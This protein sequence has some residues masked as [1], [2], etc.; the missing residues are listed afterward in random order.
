MALFLTL[1]A[2]LTAL[3]AHGVFPRL[4]RPG[5]RV[6]LRLFLAGAFSI[7]AALALAGRGHLL[8]LRPLLLALAAVAGVAAWAGL[9]RLV[10]F[11]SRRG[12]TVWRT[13][14]LGFAVLVFLTSGS[15]MGT[16]FFLM[17]G[18]LMW[19]WQRELK[20]RSRFT[21]GMLALVI[22]IMLV[23]HTGRTWLPG[24]LPRAQETLEGFAR[25]MLIAASSYA[26]LGSFVLLRAWAQDPS[27]GIRRV[28]HRLTLSHILVGLI[29]VLLVGALW[30]AT[31]ILGV[32]NERA[33]VGARAIA[34]QGHW[35]QAQLAD[36]I[37]Q[38]AS[39]EHR[40]SAF[41]AS[42]DS[43]GETELWYGRAGRF[44]RIAG[45][46]P[47]SS[48]RLEA[49][50]A[51]LDSLPSSGVVKMVDS[52]YVGAAATAQ[53]GTAAVMLVPHARATAG[54]PSEVSRVELQLLGIG[55]TRRVGPTTFQSTDDDSSTGSGSAAEQDSLPAAHAVNAA[56]ELA[57]SAQAADSAQLARSR[58]IF[59][60][61][62]IPDR[63]I[64][65]D[66]R[67]DSKRGMRISVGRES[68]ALREE[69][70]SFLMQGHA[71]SAGI[72]WTAHGWSRAQFM[73]T[74]SESPLRVLLGLFHDIRTNPLGIIPVILVGIFVILA[75]LVLAWNLMMVNGMG[76]SIT[77]AVTAL[78]GAA[79]RLRAGDLSHRIVIAGE[80]DLWHV[81]E[82]LNTATDGLQRA[83]D[84]EKIQLRMENELDVARRIQARL[85]PAG[86]PLVG[87]LEVAGYY[88]PAREVGGDYYDHIA[89]DEHRVLLV[90][91]DVSG[92]S[93]PAALIMAGFR[94]AL[95]SQDLSRGDP[96]A[97][98]E[99]LNG[100]LND[101][102]DP[103][104]FVTAFIAIVDGES[105]RVSYVNAGHNPPL[106]LRADGSHEQLEDGGNILGIIAAS[107][108]ARGEA[109]LMPGDVLLLYTDGV[110]EGM[111][112]ASELWGDDRLLAA[113]QAHGGET[114]DALVHSIANL[115]RD[116]EAERGPAD[117]VT[118]IAVRR[119]PK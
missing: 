13:I 35:Y 100:F 64:T 54:M 3:H 94:A 1:V 95:V 110:P 63:A 92:K 77:N 40:L 36:A 75:L 19:H 114:C 22:G 52:L 79:G 34:A 97:L 32:L 25:A 69:P 59:R 37:A 2:T 85:L 86:A 55:F 93:V 7:A 113:L 117:D 27:L 20:T 81:A 90:I 118:L 29:P 5:F 87:G 48:N 102:L 61:P 17:L 41:G 106:L 56:P 83:R 42:I 26:L 10:S 109:T 23:I 21:L 71:L 89:L 105:G 66:D 43:L 111:S 98:A 70:D 101:S 28:A 62:G 57:G 11:E 8:G 12:E 80:D 58:R 67:L 38:P 14:C 76:R 15:T 39:A 18:T 31:T 65:T 107:R 16:A 50:T 72:K 96:P 60:Q 9:I 119:T 104:K 53:D 68:I 74:A 116:F 82:A 99:R 45:R 78:D 108:Y 44:T 73:L 6:A 33:I 24:A 84:A 112:P 47:I 30:T 46:A 49:W 51:H 103:G 115:V 4:P 88:D 91:A